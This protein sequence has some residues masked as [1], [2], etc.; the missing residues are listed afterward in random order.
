MHTIFDCR[1]LYEP[2]AKSILDE[3]DSA[4]VDFITPH[5]KMERLKRE[6]IEWVVKLT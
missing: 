2:E 3:E 4:K 1:S 5:E 6:I